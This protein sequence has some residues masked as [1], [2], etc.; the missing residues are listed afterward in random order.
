MDCWPFN[1]LLKALHYLINDL[2]KLL[3]K[4]KREDCGRLLGF[5][6]EFYDIAEAG[7]LDK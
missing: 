7:E 5:K 1:V 2:N 4:W 3:K 6:S